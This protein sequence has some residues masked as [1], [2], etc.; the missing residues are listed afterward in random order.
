M[1]YF[2]DN[3][4]NRKIIKLVISPP[5]CPHHSPVCDR[6]LVLPLYRF[7]SAFSSSVAVKPRS[8]M[9]SAC[10]M[11]VTN[12]VSLRVRNSNSTCRPYDSCKASEVRSCPSVM[13]P[14]TKRLLPPNTETV[15]TK[16]FPIRG[17]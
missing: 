6:L 17:K 11:D 12:G 1:R 9:S 7:V 13:S 5:F 10:C 2:W 16:P 3:L 4:Y 14:E 8:M 15:Q